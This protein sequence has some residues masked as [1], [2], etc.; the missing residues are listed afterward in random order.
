M[1]DTH[2]DAAGDL[3]GLDDLINAAGEGPAGGAEP[4]SGDKDVDAS[5]LQDDTTC[6]PLAAAVNPV[7]GSFVFP[8]FTASFDVQMC[9]LRALVRDAGVGASATQRALAADVTAHLEHV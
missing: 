3:D 1:A 6:A 8:R 5:P 9:G 4:H 7:H 2:R